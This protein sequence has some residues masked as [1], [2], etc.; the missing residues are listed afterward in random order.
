MFNVEKITSVNNVR[1]SVKQ[2]STTFGVREVFV[3]QVSFE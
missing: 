2:S 1:Q 3:E